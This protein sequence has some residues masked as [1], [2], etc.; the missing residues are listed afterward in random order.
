MPVRPRARQPFALP[1]PARP[2][3]PARATPAPAHGS[4]LPHPPACARTPLPVPVRRAP[5]RPAA[6]CPARA[7]P[8]S[9]APHPG[10]LPRV[11]LCPAAASVASRPR[12]RRCHRL[13]PAR[14]RG[15]PP[16]P[17]PHAVPP[18]PPP[19]A[20]TAHRRPQIIIVCLVSL[21][22]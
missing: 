8:C 22:K 20:P 11:A 1:A 7:R 4:T 3:A 10:P 15:P 14:P 2:C 18:L 17:R 19:Q 12:G 16:P 6:L 21:M 9:C 5:P 13:A